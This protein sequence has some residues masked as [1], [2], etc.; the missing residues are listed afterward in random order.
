MIEIRVRL[1]FFFLVQY[2]FVQINV[3]GNEKC[4][5]NLLTKIEN[6]MNGGIYTFIFL[7]CY[8]ASYK[9][10]SNHLSVTNKNAKKMVS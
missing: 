8:K 7:V 2:E 4:S 1:F 10:D 9:H 3:Q 6:K 5:S